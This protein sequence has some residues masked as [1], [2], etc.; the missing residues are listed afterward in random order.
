MAD[1]SKKVVVFPNQSDNNSA[2]CVVIMHLQ[3]PTSKQLKKKLSFT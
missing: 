2:R 1:I 3:E